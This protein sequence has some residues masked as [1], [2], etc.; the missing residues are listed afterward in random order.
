MLLLL[1]RH[2]L[3]VLRLGA[4]GHVLLLRVHHD[5]VHAWLALRVD[6]HWL[7]GWNAWL[8]LIHWICSWLRLL[9]AWSAGVRLP[10]DWIVE[11]GHDGAVFANDEE[12]DEDAGSPEV[13]E[14]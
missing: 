7:T 12:D 9:G 2:G 3:I 6:V 4:G 8:L 5:R 11:S 10:F 1:H 14:E 13:G